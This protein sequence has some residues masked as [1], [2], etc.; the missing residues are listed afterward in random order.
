MP[1]WPGEETALSMPD[2]GD[3]RQAGGDAVPA[4][5]LQAVARHDHQEFADH[6]IGDDERHDKADGDVEALAMAQSSR[7][8]CSSSNTVAPSMVGT[9]R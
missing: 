8:S 3:Q 9:A 1:I 6:Q 7:L 5:R 2:I 4:E